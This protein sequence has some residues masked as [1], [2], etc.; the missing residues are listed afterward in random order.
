M[1]ANFVVGRG[2]V[3]VH[4]TPDLDQVLTKATDIVTQI[5][6]RIPQLHGELEALAKVMSSRTA[7]GM[8]QMLRR[9]RDLFKRND[10]CPC[11]S[12]RTLIACCLKPR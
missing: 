3:D 12:G 1:H 2:A 7:K 10:H 4:R 5:V 9:N 8:R 6:T 11:Y